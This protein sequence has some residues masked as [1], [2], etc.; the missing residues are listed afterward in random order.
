MGEGPAMGNGATTTVTM[1]MDE[2]PAMNDGA[3]TTVA[4]GTG[5]AATTTVT[6]WAMER[7]WV[8]QRNRARMMDTGQHRWKNSGRRQQGMNTGKSHD[9]WCDGLC[10]G[11]LVLRYLTWKIG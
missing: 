9:A 10:H 3:T 2:G 8:W 11:W 7:R 4:V 1:A 6:I 5:V